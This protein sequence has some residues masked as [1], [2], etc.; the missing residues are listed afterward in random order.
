MG[1]SL[2]S[3]RTRFHWSGV[4][5]ELLS[6][7]GKALKC[8]KIIKP[9]DSATALE[10]LDNGI[11]T[12]RVEQLCVRGNL[13]SL[14]KSRNETSNYGCQLR[15]QFRNNWIPIFFGTWQG[16]IGLIA[17]RGSR[18]RRERMFFSSSIQGSSETSTRTRVLQFWS[19]K[20][21]I[22]EKKEK[23]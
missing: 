18:A 5:D 17:N 20:K 12:A 11:V 14:Y 13:V 3:Y 4:G 2:N 22:K 15:L 21:K 23:K 9:G 16:G 1:R 6:R 7:E 10:A 8:S 19:W